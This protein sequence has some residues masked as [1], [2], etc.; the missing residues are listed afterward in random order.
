MDFQEAKYLG[1]ELADA[2]GMDAKVL[3][4]WVER[5]LVCPIQHP[6]QGYYRQF[7]VRDALR[8]ALLKQLQ[9]C[10]LSLPLAAGIADNLELTYDGLAVL[11][12]VT[13]APNAYLVLRPAGPVGFIGQIYD[14]DHVEPQLGEGGLSGMFCH[15]MLVL[16]LSFIGEMLARLGKTREA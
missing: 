7:S 5:G 3:R 9:E 8:V 14:L 2:I 10:G 12:D 4:T 16:K 13:S 11:L 15:R 1:I 6:G